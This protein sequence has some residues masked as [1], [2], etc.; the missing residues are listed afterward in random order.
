MCDRRSTRRPP[1][2]LRLV[3]G[4]LAPLLA[5]ACA[6]PSQATLA[7]SAVPSHSAPAAPATPVGP[8]ASEDRGA[9]LEARTR[10][11]ILAASKGDFALASRDF[12]DEVKK[13]MPPSAFATA[14]A[15]V[16]KQVG[17]LQ[18]IGS[19]A[20]KKTGA[21]WTDDATC[22]FEHASLIVAVTYDDENRI[23]GLHFAPA[24]SKTSWAPPSYANPES[25]EEHPVTVGAA[26]PLPGVLTLPRRSGAAP[27]VILVH[28]SGPNDEDETIEGTKPFKDLA[29]G[30]AS[31]GVAVLRYVKRTRQDPS[32]VTT[33]KEE[34]LEGVRDALTLARG[35]PV[36]DQNRVFVLGHSQGGY[37]APRIVRENPGL[38][39]AVILAGSTRPLQD[40]VIDQLV[41]LSSLSDSAGSA[42]GP[43]L[44]EAR[45]AKRRIED[46][47]L[48][49]GDDVS[50][51]GSTLKGAYFLDLRGY[52]P[53]AV[54][55]SLD[56]RLLVLQ[57][58]R[59][60]QVTMKEFEGWRTALGARPTASLKS[61]PSLNHLFVKGE[62]AP[63]P[64]EYA[65]FGHVDAAVIEDVAAWVKAKR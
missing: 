43:A 38:A 47:A 56:C 31:R 28:G 37:L 61:Y 3:L 21:F 35:T 12:G 30:L 23:G 34:V 59:D 11:L 19:V 60:Y 2:A 13:A 42:L 48:K 50:L 54:A 18:T 52:D 39:G 45:N 9:L 64:A 25:F 29:W 63:S 4:A 49:A 36:I 26:H 55:R 32:G 65:T 44:E 16:E 58:E 40:S 22:A 6:G 14:W 33:S 27:L 20:L 5:A 1:S 15:T 7:P 62:G 41:Y 51:A 57:G 8:T 10:N 17:K 53:P 24:E 46:P